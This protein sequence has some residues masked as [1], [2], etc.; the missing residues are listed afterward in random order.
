[1]LPQALLWQLVS[2]DWRRNLNIQSA[3]CCI[4][5]VSNL[6]LASITLFLSQT[7]PMGAMWCVITI[8]SFARGELAPDFKSISPGAKQTSFFFKLAFH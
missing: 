2:P 6:V 3:C 4:L 8:K 1:M 5:S 7:D